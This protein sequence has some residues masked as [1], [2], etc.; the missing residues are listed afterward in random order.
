MYDV[1]KS[2]LNIS[3]PIAA[4]VITE[5]NTTVHKYVNA[6][7]GII[8]R[9]LPARDNQNNEI[10]TS[11]STASLI[12]GRYDLGPGRPSEE[13]NKPHRPPKPRNLSDTNTLDGE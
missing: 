3:Q 8:T 12:E 7:A 13:D 10:M 4:P 11:G 5:T 2:L 6:A 1:P 9:P